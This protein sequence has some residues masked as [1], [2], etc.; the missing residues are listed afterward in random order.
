MTEGFKD[1]VGDFYPYEVDEPSPP[2]PRLRW[3][4]CPKC[5]GS[6]W[7]HSFFFGFKWPCEMCGESGRV[8]LDRLNR[9]QQIL[10]LRQEAELR[11]AARAAG[12]GGGERG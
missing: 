12:L 2:A 9:R 10:A 3:V 5:R 8:R 11:A 6:G 4:E 1:T 7:T